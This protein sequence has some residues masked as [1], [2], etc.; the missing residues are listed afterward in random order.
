[1]LKSMSRLQRRLRIQDGKVK[2]YYSA[3]K[4]DHKSRV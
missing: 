1:M 4:E 3:M 2:V